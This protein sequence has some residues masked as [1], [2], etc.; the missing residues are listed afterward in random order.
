LQYN[1]VVERKNRTLLDIVCCFLADY[2]LPGPLWAEVVQA[3]YIIINLRLS[4]ATLDK[5]PNE[6]FSGK[7]PNISKLRTFGA[8]AYVF[9]TKP[10]KT[11]FAPR[12]RP[13]VHLGFDNRTKGYCCYDPASRTIVISKDIRF[14]EK[15]APLLLS[16]DIDP[17]S[18]VTGPNTPISI[19][20]T[21]SLFQ[22]NVFPSDIPSPIPTHSSPIPVS[23]PPYLLLPDPIVESLPLVHLPVIDPEPPR[24]SKRL[25]TAPKA[26][27]D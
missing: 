22:P 6:L 24:C 21:P 12:S 9:D 13:C 10:G 7:K 17:L 11:K 1:G 14:L 25:R 15:A 27:A 8:T 23:S 16:P 2:L 3:A 4:K 20:T 26:H 19:S 18:S 5:T